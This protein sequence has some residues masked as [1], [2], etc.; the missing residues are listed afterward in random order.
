MNI[1]SIVL[2]CDSPIYLSDRTVVHKTH[3]RV[4]NQWAD[5]KAQSAYISC[6]CT[7]RTFLL[8]LPVPNICEKLSKKLFKLVL[9]PVWHLGEL[10]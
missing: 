1:N 2:T 10:V 7:Y 9:M 8:F 4:Y 5:V 3:A 6:P